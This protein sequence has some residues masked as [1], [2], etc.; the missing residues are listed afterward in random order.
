[1]VFLEGN[2]MQGSGARLLDCMFFEGSWGLAFAR[3]I[4][5]SAFTFFSQCAPLTRKHGTSEHHD[6]HEVLPKRRGSGA[7][8]LGCFFSS[9]FFGGVV[10]WSL[11]FARRIL[12][13]FPDVRSS[14]SP[15]HAHVFTSP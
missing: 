14:L 4:F 13:S 11:K 7:K 9:S 3:R 6:R 12:G 10:S 1:M 5:G 2:E 8:P 15:Q